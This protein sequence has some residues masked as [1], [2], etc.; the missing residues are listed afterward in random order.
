MCWS[1]SRA[2]R[3]QDND[4]KLYRKEAF[5][6]TDGLLNSYRLAQAETPGRTEALGGIQRVA[7]LV[8][9]QLSLIVNLGLFLQRNPG[10]EMHD[11]DVM[12]QLQQALGQIEALSEGN[13]STDTSDQAQEAGARLLAERQREVEAR[14]RHSTDDYLPAAYDLFWLENALKIAA[15]ASRLQR[16]MKEIGIGV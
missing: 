6:K 7:L 1:R 9:T 3:P 15:T 2:T 16:K 12:A 4:Y 11:R 10:Y 14:L 5:L 13:V 8:Y